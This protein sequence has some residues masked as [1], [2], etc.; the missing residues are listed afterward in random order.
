MSGLRRSQ[1]AA[2]V[3]STLVGGLLLISL[4]IALSVD[5]AGASRQL[6]T[7]ASQPPTASIHDTPPRPGEPCRN[8][9]YYAVKFVTD[10]NGQIR[11]VFMLAG[12]MTSGS[13]DLSA[14]DAQ[15]VAN[16]DAYVADVQLGSYEPSDPA[17]PKS[18]PVCRLNP[19]YHFYCP[20]TDALD[21]LCLTWVPR[22][23]TASTP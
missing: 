13:L 20:A 23:S 21:Q 17:E 1:S 10:S 14:A 16:H 7:A 22:R 5:G 11:A 9:H 2:L 4:L 6:G 19:T 3:S 15:L 18:E 12:G 8:T